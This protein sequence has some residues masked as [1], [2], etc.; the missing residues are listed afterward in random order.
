MSLPKTLFTAVASLVAPIL[1]ACSPLALLERAVP[2]DTYRLSSAIAYGTHPRQQL[3]VYAP[4]DT[5][6]PAPVLVFIYG[7]NWNSGNRDFYRFVGEAFAARGIVTVIPDYRLY[8]EVKFPD[9]LVDSANATRWAIDNAAKFGGD[10]KRVYIGG[11][12]AGAYNAAMVALDPRYARAAGFDSTQLAG[13]VGLAGPYDFLPLTGS[14]TRAVFGFP[15]TSPATQPIN[16]VSS[17]AP[18]S[19]LLYAPNDNIVGRH[20]SEN[21]S[22]KLREAGVDVRLVP[23]DGLGHRTLVGSIARPLAWMGNTADEIAAFVR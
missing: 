6:T 11:H 17:R 8:P 13:F 3:D 19:L 10:P 12:S 5:K 18:R 23:Y 15:D 16:F 1:S 7:G 9:F 4:L 2:S 20:N 21:L 22:T 14:I